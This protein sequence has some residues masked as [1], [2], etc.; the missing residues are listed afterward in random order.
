MC[1]CAASG[2]RGRDW[3]RAQTQFR[4]FLPANWYR[5]TATLYPEFT[6]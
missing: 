2:S 5:K 3:N 6:F 4:S 1:V